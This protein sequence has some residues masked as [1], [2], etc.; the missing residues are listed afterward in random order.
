MRMYRLEDVPV[1][2]AVRVAS[3]LGGETPGVVTEVDRDIKNGRPGIVYRITGDV[4]YPER[5]AYLDQ[6]TWVGVNLTKVLV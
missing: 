4:E 2:A 3:W 5:W 1:G 6:V